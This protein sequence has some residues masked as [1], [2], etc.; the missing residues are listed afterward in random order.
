MTLSI[1]SGVLV[2]ARCSSQRLPNKVLL[3]F[4]GMPLILWVIRRAQSSGLPVVLATSINGS[5]DLLARLTEA[6]GITV[7][8]GELNDV[9]G[10]ALAAAAH[11]GWHSFARLCAD[12]PFFDVTQMR[13]ALALVNGTEQFDLVTNNLNGEAAPGLTIEAIRIEALQRAGAAS[14]MPRHREHLSSYIY[15]HKDCFKVRQLAVCPIPGELKSKRFAVDTPDDY[16]LLHAMADG[17]SPA[18]SLQELARK[19]Q[20]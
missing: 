19:V 7:I 10:R 3:E 14:A 2:F 11:L 20:T 4:S 13:D 6:A 16:R 18:V 1:V 15:E 8:R 12:R 9:L 17:C 5:D